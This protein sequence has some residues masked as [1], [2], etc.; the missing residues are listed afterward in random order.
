MK[1][2]FWYF[3]RFSLTFGFISGQELESLERIEDKLDRV[4]EENERLKEDLE[5]K[6]GDGKGDEEDGDKPS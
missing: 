2:I 3:L 4:L 6:D 1:Y 5:K